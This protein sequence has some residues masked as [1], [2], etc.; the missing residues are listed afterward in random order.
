MIVLLPPSEGKREAGPRARPLAL[1]GLSFPS[2]TAPRERVLDALTALSARPDAGA[3]LGVSPRL[4]AEVERN[5]RLRI[6][7][8]AAAA[9]VYSGVLYAAL[10]LA[11]LDPQARRRAARR[12]IVVSAL[13][14]AL[15]ITD[16]I[17]AYRL[18]MGVDLPP[19]G[20]LAPLWRAPLSEALVPVSSGVIVDCRSAPYAAAWAPPPAA[21]ERWVHVQI[22][23]ASHHAKHTRGLVARALVASPDTPRRLSQVR[24]VVQA[25]GDW[26]V[27]LREPARR[28]G[29]WVL[30]VSPN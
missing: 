28:S 29:P 7:P 21:A 4:S 2:L 6:E 23:G 25:G 5:G 27:Q 30:A 11:G 1:S 3:L 13:F 20:P 12:L 19:L 14:G 8:A 18:A 26:Q 15:R 24:E 22:P 10:D 9:D 16:R 17:P